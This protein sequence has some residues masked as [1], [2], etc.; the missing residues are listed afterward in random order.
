MSELASS[1]SIESIILTIL[2]AI[3]III[4]A[5]CIYAL[6]AAILKFVFSGGDTE[7]IK[8]ARNSIRY[9][10]I[11]II[12]T[13]VLLFLFPYVFQFLSVPGYKVYTAQNIFQKAGEILQWGWTTTQQITEDFQKDQFRNTEDSLDASPAI[14]T[15]L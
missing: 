11:G 3:V 14:N 12:L 8:Q 1:P 2:A 4:C 15:D 7:K 5:W 9:M 10:I 13:M 6:V